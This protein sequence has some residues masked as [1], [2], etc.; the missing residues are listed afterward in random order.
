MFPA[1]IGNRHPAIR[2]AQNGHDLAFGKSALLHQNLLNN[3]AEKI[4]LLKPLIFRGD[5]PAIMRKL[6][7]LVNALLRKNQ[8]WAPKHA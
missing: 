7:V 8:K 2:L 3:L 6:I 4:L 1:K 5:Y